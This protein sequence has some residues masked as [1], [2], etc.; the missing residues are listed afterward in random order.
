MRAF[1]NLENVSAG[2]GASAYEIDIQTALAA[3][4][5][6]TLPCKIVLRVFN[7]EAVTTKL[8]SFVAPD[9]VEPVAADNDFDTAECATGQGFITT[10]PLDVD[11][12]TVNP[13]LRG[14]V[15]A[16]CNV[17]GYVLTG[18]GA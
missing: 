3:V 1:L 9:I 11:S 5:W 13:L 18:G 4:D 2:N 10:F 8:V 12:T 17:T 16:A 7:R 15:A 6:V 14:A